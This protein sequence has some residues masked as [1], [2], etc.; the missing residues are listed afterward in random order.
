MTLMK[1]NQLNDD[2]AKPIIAV[3]RKRKETKDFEDVILGSI[4]GYENVLS[5]VNKE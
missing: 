3:L 4:N 2:E 1:N 5:I